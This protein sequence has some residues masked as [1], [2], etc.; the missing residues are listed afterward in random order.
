M[1]ITTRQLAVSALLVAADVLFVRVFALNT[2]IMKIGL[3]FAAIAL[4]AMAYGPWWAAG[5]SALG[6]LLG[7]LLFPHRGV[8]SR[9]HSHG[10]NNRHDLRSRPL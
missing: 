7:S 9:L 8:F 2:P 5:V 3:G 10:G 4:C 6:D 1:K